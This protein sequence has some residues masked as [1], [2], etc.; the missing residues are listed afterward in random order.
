MDHCM[1]MYVVS[2]NYR[3][4]VINDFLIEYENTYVNIVNN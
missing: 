2:I 4:I 1:W 3:K